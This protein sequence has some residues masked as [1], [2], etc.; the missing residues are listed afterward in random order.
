MLTPNQAR[1][2]VSIV[3]D[4]EKTAHFVYEANRL[5]AITD[6]RQPA[7]EPQT[8]LSVAQRQE[9]RGIAST[10]ELRSQVVVVRQKFIELCNRGV[11]A[12][13]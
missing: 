2:A 8:D 5:Q 6:G 3:M 1:V 10:A 12:L 9:V 13:F 11:E 4:P 7:K